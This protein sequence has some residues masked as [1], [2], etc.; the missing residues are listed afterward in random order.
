MI[1]NFELP[2]KKKV[3]KSLNYIE[4]AVEVLSNNPYDF[5]SNSY[6]RVEH[7]FPTLTINGT[8]MDLTSWVKQA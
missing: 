6:I 3:K 8:R 7:S 4:M 2:N 1:L 5:Y